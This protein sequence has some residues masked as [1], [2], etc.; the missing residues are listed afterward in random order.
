MKFKLFL[1]AGG[2]NYAFGNKE[3]LRILIFQ[4]S[5]TSHLIKSG[6]LD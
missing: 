6:M 2:Y 4:L 3:F 5:C 1:E